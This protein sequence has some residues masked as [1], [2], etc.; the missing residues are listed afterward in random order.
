MTELLTLYSAGD[1]CLTCLLVAAAGV[2]SRYPVALHWPAAAEQG[3][4]GGAT[5][6][7][8]HSRDARLGSAG[9]HAERRSRE[10]R[11][12][13]AQRHGPGQHQQRAQ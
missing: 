7:A 1:I 12:G 6:C 13:A 11:P 4:S 10:G 3:V 5:V 9:G 2:V 8:D